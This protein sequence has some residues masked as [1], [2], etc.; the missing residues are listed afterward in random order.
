LVEL[1][2]TRRSHTTR[3]GQVRV[4]LSKDPSH[5]CHFWLSFK[6]HLHS[7]SSMLSSGLLVH[8]PSST[9]FTSALFHPSNQRRKPEP[10]TIPR[11]NEAN[12]VLVRRLKSVDI[13]SRIVY[14]RSEAFVSSTLICHD[15]E[16]ADSACTLRV[17]S[18]TPTG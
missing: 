1:E 9:S 15:D 13:G 6:P 17:P 2:L 16:D 11:T 3:L 18:L 7:V 14:I 8:Q 4:G 10:K 12:Q 5:T